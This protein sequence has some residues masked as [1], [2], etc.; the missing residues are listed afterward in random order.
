MNKIKCQSINTKLHWI[1]HVYISM[2]RD[3]KMHVYFNRVTIYCD[4]DT[5]AHVMG[6]ESRLFQL[7][8]CKSFDSCATCDDDDELDEIQNWKCL[9]IERRSREFRWLERCETAMNIRA[10]CAYISRSFVDMNRN[11]G[12]I[13]RRIVLEWLCRSFTHEEKEKNKSLA[14]TN[15][16]SRQRGKEEMVTKNVNKSQIIEQ[17]SNSSRWYANATRSCFEKSSIGRSIGLQSEHMWALTRHIVID[18]SSCIHFFFK[19]TSSTMQR[20]F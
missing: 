6:G 10:H 20:Y 12:L 13:F 7:R 14:T 5:A 1:S 19:V 18:L 15:A 9:F 8:H 2:S 17:I 3:A 16:D 11:L 4:A